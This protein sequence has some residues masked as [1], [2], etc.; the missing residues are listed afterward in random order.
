MREG[1]ERLRCVERNV[2]TDH[3]PLILSGVPVPERK[4]YCQTDKQYCQYNREEQFYDERKMLFE[5]LFGL[6]G[7]ARGRSDAQLSVEPR[8]GVGF[9]PSCLGLKQEIFPDEDPWLRETLTKRQIE[10]I[11]PEDLENIRVKGLVP[12]AVKYIRYF[13]TKLEEKASVYV[14]FTWG[15]F[16]LAHLIRGDKIFID[17]YRDPDFVHHLMR[18]TTRLYIKASAIL[19]ES[20]G[21]P[22]HQGYHGSYYMDNSGVWS[23]ED[24]IVL[25][26][27]TLAEEFVFPYLRRAYKPFGGAVIHL[28]GR[29]DHL[30]E[31]LLDI[32][33][34]KGIN[35]GEPGK[36]EQSYKQIMKTVLE[37]GK[38]YFGGWPKRQEENT[39][40][41]FKRI[42][43]PLKGEK[44]GLVL[45]Y[46]P[47]KKEKKNPQ[48]VMELWHSLQK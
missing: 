3:L 41:Y 14:S 16:S 27:P 24:T 26:S 6:I 30:L 15:P 11:Q 19:K 2:E 12:T 31:P 18:I 10:R 43:K 29:T 13:R 28:C 4:E 21:E 9:L 39:E 38:T 20:A 23:N 5:Q 44:R 47:N 33:E 40:T 8:M 37:K 7:T 22:K 1:K 36:Q 34:I 17:L 48:K 32:P 25:L 45:N 42:L 46:N 35:L